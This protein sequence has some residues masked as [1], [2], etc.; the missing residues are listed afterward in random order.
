MKLL[1]L[2]GAPRVR[3]LDLFPTA[4]PRSIYSCFPFDETAHGKLKRI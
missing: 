1:A 4:G 3:A 2:A